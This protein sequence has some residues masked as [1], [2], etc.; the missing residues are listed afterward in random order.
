MIKYQGIAKRYR[1]KL[2][3][4]VIGQ[5]AIVTTLKN[6]IQ[7]KRIVHG[8]LFC[9]PRGTGKTTL[10]RLFAKA[11]NCSH[12]QEE[13]EPCNHCSSC[14]EITNGHSLDVMEIDGASNRG[15]DDIR[16]LNETVKYASSP[17]KYKIYIIDEV[18]M[19]T[20]E[21]FNALLKTLED[22][23]VHVLFFF[24]TTEPHKVLST[25][26]SRC[27]RFDLR[28]ISQEQIEEA[29]K[30][31]AE[32]IEAQIETAALSLIAERAEGSL[33]DAQSLLDQ[34][35]CFEQTPV[36]A[37]V[38]S[39]ALGLVSKEIFFSLDRAAAQNN[40]AFAF[41]TA[42][43][44][45]QK[46]GDHNFFLESLMKHYRNLL[47]LKLSKNQDLFPS[48][49]QQD[50]EKY[51]ESASFYTQEQCL[52]ILQYLIQM[53]EGK[54]HYCLSQLQ[55]E[56][57]LLYIIRCTKKIPLNSLVERLSELREAINTPSSLQQ[58]SI[59]EKAT[60]PLKSDPLSPSAPATMEDSDIQK[61]FKQE[62]AMC[63]TSIALNG[64]LKR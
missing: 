53:H 23:P 21:A 18:H 43:I 61:K 64:V 49:T 62:R 4:E 39:N 60:T 47:L 24:A 26:L 12:L 27:Q 8:Y 29:L 13:G 59:E 14:I 58:P 35:F 15:I 19:L 3:K 42:A 32:D 7:M 20:K 34:I 57:I 50:L 54:A 36:T 28:R 5:K 6:A 56:M 44:L 16:Q 31:I 48:L 11:L 33:R 17:G 45:F 10:A 63:F 38:V 46:G 2:F 40:L 37:A 52:D 41:E 55:I 9:G 22:P 1:P 51:Q 30:K 25:I